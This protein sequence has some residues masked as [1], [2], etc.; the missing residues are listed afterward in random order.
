MAGGLGAG[1]I[2]R[3][4]YLAVTLDGASCYQHACV[5]NT[6]H[7]TE[8]IQAA[9]EQRAARAEAERHIAAAKHRIGGT[10][11]RMIGPDIRQAMA[12]EAMVRSMSSR[13]S[14][15]GDTSVV[16]VRR[17]IAAAAI[18]MAHDFE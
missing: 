7:T 1:V 18:I 13:S 3:S 10:A 16:Q 5:V 17:M 8:S 15:P 12:C 6:T 11:W 2:A 9:D 14:D 4:N